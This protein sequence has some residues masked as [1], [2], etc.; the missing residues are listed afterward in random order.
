MIGDIIDNDQK[1]FDF[2]S[3]MSFSNSIIEY[4]EPDTTRDLSKIK[5]DHIIYVDNDELL[6]KGFYSDGLHSPSVLSL[7]T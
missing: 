3:G 4:R 5:G 6:R 2:Q 7:Y 1:N